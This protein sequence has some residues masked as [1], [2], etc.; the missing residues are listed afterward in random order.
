VEKALVA[1]SLVLFSYS[2]VR[3]MIW[4]HITH[5]K[6][7][8]P[9]TIRIFGGGYYDTPKSDE[10]RGKHKATNIFF[11]SVHNNSFCVQVWDFDE[12][13]TKADL[14]TEL[15]YTI[16]GMGVYLEA[17]KQLQNIQDMDNISVVVSKNGNV[18]LE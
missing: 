13:F 9:Y 6:N 14:K 7:A 2:S 1:A 5:I 16:K 8:S 10:L 4:A 12:Q 3:T 17:N 18:T 15:S 11:D